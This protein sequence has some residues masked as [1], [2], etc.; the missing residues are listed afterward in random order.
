MDNIL[1]VLLVEQALSPSADSQKIMSMIPC[2]AYQQK[3]SIFSMPFSVSTQS[4]KLDCWT[5]GTS[6]FYSLFFF[7]LSSLFWPEINTTLLAN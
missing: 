6:N 3:R 5:V 4:S 1:S 2:I 7:F